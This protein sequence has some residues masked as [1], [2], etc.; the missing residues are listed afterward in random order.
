[1]DRQFDRWTDKKYVF[2]NCR[3]QIITRGKIYELLT[4]GATVKENHP[5]LHEANLQK[6]KYIGDIL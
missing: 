6:V 2:E 1:M 4:P 5:S 3:P